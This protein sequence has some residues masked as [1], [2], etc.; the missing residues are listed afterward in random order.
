MGYVQR[1]KN[2]HLDLACPVNMSFLASDL[3]VAFG[4]EW[5]E[6]KFEI[7]GGEPGWVGIKSV[8][9]YKPYRPFLQT[10]VSSF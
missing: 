8:N 1:G 7:E 9:L 4:L 2:V 10:A 3:N 6:E 5:R